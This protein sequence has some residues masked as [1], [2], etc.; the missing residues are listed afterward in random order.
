MRWFICLQLLLVIGTCR[1]QRPPCPYMCRKTQSAISSVSKR[2]RVVLV[3]HQFDYVR[4]HRHIFSLD[5]LCFLFSYLICMP[6]NHFKNSCY[7]V[8]CGNQFPRL[9]T[10]YSPRHMSKTSQ[11]FS[12]NRS[13]EAVLEIYSVPVLS[14]LIASSATSSQASGLFVT[15]TVSKPYL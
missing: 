2:D 1:C 4:S 10:L 6:L 12:P 7:C 14:I 15:A 8:L 5:V 13:T 3:W 11:P 9:H